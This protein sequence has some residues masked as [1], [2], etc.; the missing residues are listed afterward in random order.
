MPSVR[1]TAR[2]SST[3]TSSRQRDGVGFGPRPAGRLRDRRRHRRPKLTNSGNLAGSP[4]YMAPEQAQNEP[5]TV[6]TDLWGLGATLYFAVEG[7]PPFAESGAIATLTSVVNAPHRP[8]ERASALVPLIDA[9]LAKRPDDRP[10]AA[11]TRRRLTGCAPDAGHRCAGRV[12]G[13]RSPDR[14]GP[15][16]PTDG[17][18]RLA[19]HF[20]GCGPVPPE[21]HRCRHRAQELGRLPGPRHRVGHR[22]SAGLDGEDRWH[23][24]RLS[25]SRF[26]GLSAG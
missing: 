15:R 9:L 10:S 2:P 12:G 1:P 6:A 18:Q 23:A 26:R 11:E 19:C 5:P 20:I 21:V 4:S 3:A 13:S 22:P 8:L 25:G 16:Q 24:H 7:R 14:T 17:R